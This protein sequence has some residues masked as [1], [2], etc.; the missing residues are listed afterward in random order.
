MRFTSNTISTLIVSAVFVGCWSSGYLAARLVSGM[1]QPFNLLLL[2][3]LATTAILGFVVLATH[4]MAPLDKPPSCDWGQQAFLGILYHVVYIGCVFY[5]VRLGLSAGVAAVAFATQPILTAMLEAVVLRRF[6]SARISAAAGLCISGVWLLGG[7]ALGANDQ[8]FLPAGVAGIGVVAISV[9][10]LFHSRYL[11]DQPVLLSLLT[12]FAAATVCIALLLLAGVEPL[13]L[14]LDL[15]K[16]TV[17]LFLVL[18]TTMGSYVA[19]HWLIA[20][21]SASTY[22]LLFYLVPPTVFAG[23]YIIFSR[24]VSALELAGAL[25]MLAGVFIG[26]SRYRWPKRR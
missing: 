17:V 12:Q 20:N 7:L 22:S 1:F 26:V 4:K 8:Q 25:I 6:P 5:A 21:M 14:K 24:S 10:T 13:N 19:M 16:S 23:E 9:A 11:K 3:Y 18:I 15:Y 2:R